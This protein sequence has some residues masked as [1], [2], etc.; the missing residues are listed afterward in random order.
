MQRRAPRTRGPP[1][2]EQL[3]DWEE[4][5]TCILFGD[6]AGAVVLEWR[7]GRRPVLPEPPGC[8]RRRSRCPGISPRTW[9]TPT[10]STAPLVRQ[11]LPRG[12]PSPPTAR[13]PPVPPPPRVATAPM[14]K[15]T[16]L[17]MA[18][19]AVFKF[20]H[21]RHDALHREALTAPG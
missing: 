19:Q 10:T 17:R 5:A 13:P 18:G 4:R 7:D 1:A 14:R 3:V 9:K 2:P 20:A 11:R 15:A 6:G 12:C 8:R 21:L 16:L